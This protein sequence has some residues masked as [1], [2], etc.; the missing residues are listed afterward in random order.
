MR[1]TIRTPKQKDFEETIISDDDKN[2]FFAL[3]D[4][5]PE[6]DEAPCIPGI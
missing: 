1:G 2:A 4:P 5:D 6:G 3:N